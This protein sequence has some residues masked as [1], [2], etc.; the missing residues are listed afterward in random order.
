MGLGALKTPEERSDLPTAFWSR[1]QPAIT[2]ASFV[3]T[4]QISS[5]PFALS[6]L[7]NLHSQLSPDTGST[8]NTYDAAGNLFTQTDAKGQVTTYAYDALSRVASIT[9]HD[10]SKQ[11]YA[12]DL[13]ANGIGRLSSISETNPQN[14]VTSL[15][16]YA[17]EDHGRVAS[18]TRTIAG[19]AYVTGYG[20]D[21]SGRLSGM[22]YPSGRVIAYGF[23]ALGR[24]SQVSTTPQGGTQQ[25]LASGITYQ[26]FGGVKSYTLGNGQST[27]RGY[28]SDGRIASYSLGTQVFAL[29]YDNAS[30]I[31]MISET[32][33]AANMNTYDYDLLDR[34][35]SAVLPNLPFAYGY[36]AV[37]NRA[38][39]TTG[40]STDTYGYGT[41]SN[42]LASV[43]APAGAVRNFSFDAN[44]STTNDGVNQYAYD[45]RGRLSQSVGALGT[46]NYQINALGQRVRKTNPTDDRIF[47]YD[48][49]GKLIE[50]ASP[51]GQTLTEYVYLGD[52]PVSVL[53]SQ[54][55]YYMHPDHLNTPRLI[56]NST[57]TTVWRWDQGEPFGNDVPN[58]NPSGAGAFDFKLRFPGQYF[59]RETNLAYNYFRDYDPAIGRYIKSDPIGLRGGLNT[60][61]YAAANPLSLTDRKGL[62]VVCL[63]PRGCVIIPDP[64]PLA[65]PPS[66]GGE[67]TTPPQ[68]D[69]DR[70]T[71]RPGRPESRPERPDPL[72]LEPP[73]T[74]NP[75][76][77]PDNVPYI[78]PENCPPNC[79]ERQQE[80]LMLRG[81]IIGDGSPYQSV[82]FF[83]ILARDH[84]SRCGL[85]F[86]VTPLSVAQ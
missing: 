82:T 33:N 67:A 44:G 36:D 16:A 56:A 23:D 72:K 21:S 51:T 84:N 24:I 64:I 27:T 70:P 63:P 5:T 58:N 60:Y 50:E 81:N 9:F 77:F 49:K 47:V 14:Q 29:N 42:R 34:L 38:S 13:G 35:T 32:G 4:H 68:S 22:T 80:L 6:C 53:N 86:Y 11:T 76:I 66:T 62:A 10:G 65:S 83:N 1:P 55:T 46:T 78:P 69:R 73:S 40:S 30:R 15:L 18:E 48:T 74:D 54:G 59:D 61:A 31:R 85:V 19:V 37:G 26:P 20:Y 8:A 41:T 12:Y 71:D 7:A 28:D 45:T 39:K 57:G 17:Y 75:I 79:R 2:K 3:A 52:I 43:T 25:I